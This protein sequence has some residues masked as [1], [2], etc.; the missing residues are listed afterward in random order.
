MYAPINNILVVKGAIT[1]EIKTAIKAKIAEFSIEGINAVVPKGIEDE[2]WFYFT[3]NRTPNE[4]EVGESVKETYPQ[5]RVFYSST[6]FDGFEWNYYK[7][8]GVDGEHKYGTGNAAEMVMILA[9][10]IRNK[11]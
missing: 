1:E 10:F 7:E 9:K 4:K 6:D 3:T 11:H 5:L 2:V 8:I